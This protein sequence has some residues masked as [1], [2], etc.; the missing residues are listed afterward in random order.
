MKKLLIKQLFIISVFFS[1]CNLNSKTSQNAKPASSILAAAK[2][3]VPPIF[4]PSADK[5]F[6]LHQDT[7]FYNERLYRADHF[8]TIHWQCLAVPH[9]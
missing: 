9:P 1:A 3:G 6:A 4:K 7:L 8:D 5:G 2:I